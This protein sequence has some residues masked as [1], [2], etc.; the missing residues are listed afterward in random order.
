MYIFLILSRIS[1]PV[2]FVLGSC[3]HRTNSFVKL[4]RQFCQDLYLYL[5]RGMLICIQETTQH[6][7]RRRN[8]WSNNPR[9]PRI[10][11]QLHG[12][13]QTTSRRNIQTHHLNS[14]KSRH[15]IYQRRVSGFWTSP[16]NFFLKK[17]RKELTMNTE[18]RVSSSTWTSPHISLPRRKLATPTNGNLP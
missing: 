10:R 14:W 6:L 13:I 18:M 17:S 3:F 8:H 9:R 15:P 4:V 12:E 2:A 7:I 16:Q 1:P 5:R 11:L